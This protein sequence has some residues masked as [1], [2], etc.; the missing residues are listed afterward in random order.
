MLFVGRLVPY[1][2]ADMAIDAIGRLSPNFKDR[3]QFTIVG[4]GSEKIQL[5]N[6]VRNLGLN[7]VVMFTG[8]VD[9]KETVQYYRNSDVFCFPSVREFGGAVALEA[10]AGGLPCIVPDHAGLGEYVTEETGFKIKPLS[11][12]YLITRISETIEEIF[13]NR[14]RLHRMSEK[15]IERVRDYEWDKKAERLVDIYASLIMGNG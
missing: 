13:Q 11:R 12:E 8:W 14:E 7:N 3:V 10:M 2:G 5:E 9:Q 6:Q 15:A 4:D 1:K